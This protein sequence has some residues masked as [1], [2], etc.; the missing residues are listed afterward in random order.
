MSLQTSKPTRMGSQEGVNDNVEEEVV[1]EE[2][3]EVEIEGDRGWE[4]YGGIQWVVGVP[5]LRQ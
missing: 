3:T 1:E 5:R 4:I 2:R